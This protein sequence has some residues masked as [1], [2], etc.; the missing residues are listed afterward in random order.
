MCSQLCQLAR[1]DQKL[2]YNHL[3]NSPLIDLY[4]RGAISTEDVYKEF[5]HVFNAAVSLQEFTVAL[6]D[7]FTLNEGIIPLLQRLKKNDVELIA[8]SNTCPAHFE[9]AMKQYPE[10]GYFDQYILSFEVGAR[11]PENKIFHAAL[12]KSSS[13]IS[14][15]FYTDDINEYVQMACSLGIASHTFTNVELLKKSLIDHGFL[16]NNPIE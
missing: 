5:C 3:F 13:E 14:Q 11:K 12:A 1:V 10:L 15:C 9:Y 6:S 7:I 16:T 2:I 8:L 4:E